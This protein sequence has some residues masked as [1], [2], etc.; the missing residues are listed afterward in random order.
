MGR[1]PTRHRTRGTSGEVTRTPSGNAAKTS[2]RCMAEQPLSSRSLGR[3]GKGA[4][5][6]RLA[7]R[8]THAKRARSARLRRARPLA[9]VAASSSGR[10]EGGSASSGC[11]GRCA[12]SSRSPRTTPA[13]GRSGRVAVSTPSSASSSSSRASPRAFVA[14]PAAPSAVR[15]TRSAAVDAF[16]RFST[17][18]R[19]R[20]RKTFSCPPHARWRSQ[21]ADWK[22]SG[23]TTRHFRRNVRHPTDFA[24]SSPRRRRADGDKN[25]RVRKRTSRRPRPSQK[26]A[27]TFQHGGFPGDSS[28]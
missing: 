11:G 13:P 10:T 18:R 2:P 14:M 8:S 24:R 16:L 26:K 17:H 22:I 3:K 21:R 6:A 4:L 19:R 5:T 25:R 1:G 9:S 28:A 20:R 15:R 7:T 27:K 23:I 12:S